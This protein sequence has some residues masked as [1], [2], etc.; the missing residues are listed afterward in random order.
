MKTNMIET[1]VNEQLRRV[2]R[3]RCFI[4]AHLLTTFTK[5]NKFAIFFIAK[6]AHPALKPLTINCSLIA[7]MGFQCALQ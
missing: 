4:G 7:I 1:D 3:R 6:A 2:F 5:K